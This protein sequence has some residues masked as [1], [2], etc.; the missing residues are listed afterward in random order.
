MSTSRRSQLVAALLLGV[1]P[2]A[3]ERNT[4]TLAGPTLEMSVHDADGVPFKGNL[5]FV[6]DIGSRVCPADYVPIAFEGTGHLTQ[7][8]RVTIAGNDCVLFTPPTARIADGVLT[9]TGA[10]GDQ[11]FA[12]IEGSEVLP[13]PEVP[14]T[15]EGTFVIVGGTGRFDGAT[16]G[17]RFSG[18]NPFGPAVS[19]DVDGTL[20]R[21]RNTASSL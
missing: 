17:G 20:S 1:V 3:C 9:I 2:A 11:L 16:G 5:D 14:G 21:V 6:T 13:T 10:N 8:G 4:E 15:V 12:E 19:A 18:I 7:L